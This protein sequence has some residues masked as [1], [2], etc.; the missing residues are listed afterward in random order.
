[1]NLVIFGSAGGTG[2]TTL[3]TNFAAMIS[4]CNPDFL[5]IDGSKEG[6]AARFME[7]RSSPHRGLRAVSLRA[8]SL[9][10]MTDAVERYAPKF[11]NVVIVADGGD[12]ALAALR[13]ADACLI[14]VAPRSS[15]TSHDVRLVRG[16]LATNSSLRVHVVFNRAFSGFEDHFEIDA[17]HITDDEDCFE[18][19][20]VV[21]YNRAAYPDAFSLAQA[22]CELDEDDVRDPLAAEEMINLF[23]YVYGPFEPQPKVERRIPGLFWQHAC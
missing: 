20:P 5:L 21:V 15:P 2:K 8:T 9:H 4:A 6:A 19:A 11:A 23:E 3:A 10:A 7:R 12:I 13:C 1:M 16:A 14:P 22:V 18:V 17:E